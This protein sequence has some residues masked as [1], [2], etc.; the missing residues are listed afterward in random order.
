MFKSASRSAQ[1]SERDP[2]YAVR[3]VGNVLT[4]FMKGEG[5]I[6]RPASI[7]WAKYRSKEHSGL[8]LQLTV[9]GQGLRVVTKD[10]VVT[11]YRA[12][13]ILYAA[14]HPKYP[15]LFVWVYRHEGKRMGVRSACC[16]NIRK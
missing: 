11:K 7:L 12:H 16:R 4:P 3:Y 1:I 2:I 5:C 6:D 13:R 14:C 8:E 15:R 10:Q 9:C